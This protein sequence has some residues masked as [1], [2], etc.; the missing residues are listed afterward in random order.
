MKI[1]N[2]GDAHCGDGAPQS[3]H[4]LFLGSFWIVC[5]CIAPF[6]QSCLLYEAPSSK[7]DAYLRSSLRVDFPH[8]FGR[9]GWSTVASLRGQE[10]PGKNTECECRTTLC[11]LSLKRVRP[12][13]YG[14]F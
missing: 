9:H 6:D 7:T 3:Q 11:I 13:K 14:L 2:F 12:T 5:S 1:P 10:G 4:M 8:G